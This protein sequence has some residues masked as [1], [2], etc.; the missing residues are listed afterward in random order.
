MQLQNKI[1]LITG[2]SP[3]ICGGIAVGMAEAGA[4]VVCVDIQPENAHGVP[5]TSS[6][7]VVRRLGS[8]AT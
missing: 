4:K 7:A 1:A 5:T 6:S 8:C 2:T 3:N